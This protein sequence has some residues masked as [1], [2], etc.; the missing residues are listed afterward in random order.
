VFIIKPIA[1]VIVDVLRINVPN[2]AQTYA[3]QRLYT[4]FSNLMYLIV[5]N[6][7]FSY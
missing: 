3:P 1:V 2:A 5:V 6:R 7:L 4:R